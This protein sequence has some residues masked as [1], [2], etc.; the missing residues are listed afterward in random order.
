MGKPPIVERLLRAADNASRIQRTLM[1]AKS[2]RQEGN[3]EGRTDLYMWPT[4]EQTLEGEAAETISELVEALRW[5]QMHALQTPEFRTHEYGLQAL[6]R[7]Q[8]ILAKVQ[9]P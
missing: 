6:V 3:P 1:E 7:T 9:Q 4:P 8:A 5:M 2:L